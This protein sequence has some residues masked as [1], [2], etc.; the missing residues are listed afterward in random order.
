MDPRCSGKNPKQLRCPSRGQ[1]AC[2]YLLGKPAAAGRHSSRGVTAYSLAACVKADGRD[3]A[4]AALLPG[5]RTWCE[6]AAAPP[7]GRPPA[8]SSGDNSRGRPPLGTRDDSPI[9]G[10]RLACKANRASSAPTRLVS[11]P[12]HRSGPAGF[13]R[14]RSRRSHRRCNKTGRSLHRPREVA[15]LK[16]EHRK[17]FGRSLDDRLWWVPRRVELKTHIHSLPVAGHRPFHLDVERGPFRAP[18]R[19]PPFTA[20]GIEA[21]LWPR[22]PIVVPATRVLSVPSLGDFVQSLEFFWDRT[23]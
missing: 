9:K 3:N 12:G 1:T 15:E 17:E 20:P 21:V 10:W 23:G 11:Q 22:V 6:L 13:S 5:P 16:A 4:G 14:R 7:G 2:I 19:D 8:L 18:I